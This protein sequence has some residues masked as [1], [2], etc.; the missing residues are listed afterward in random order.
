M[1]GAGLLR[2]PPPCMSPNWQNGRKC[3]CGHPPLRRK[4]CAALLPRPLS[5][6]ISALEDGAR[7]EEKETAATATTTDS[8]VQLSARTCRGC[9][10]TLSDRLTQQLRIHLPKWPLEL[11][12]LPSPFVWVFIFYFFLFKAM[13]KDKQ[14]KT[15]EAQWLFIY[16]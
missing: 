9:W 15:S 13:E 12:D 1:G 10:E 11:L 8:H 7:Q 2:P 14:Q 4:R 16:N 6:A 5:A 3:K